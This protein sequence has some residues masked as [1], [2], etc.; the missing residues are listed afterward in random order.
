[1]SQIDEVRRLL[2]ERRDELTTE[3]SR[4]EGAITALG[5]SVA[6]D[7][8]RRAGGSQRKRAAPGKGGAR[9]PRGISRST[10]SKSS[11][12]RAATG[13]TP[14]VGGSKV[15]ASARKSR[16]GRRPKATR[17][18]RL[19]Q[20]VRKKPGIRVAEAAKRMNA[21]A[22]GLYQVRDRLVETGKVR[23]VGKGLHPG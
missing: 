1:M 20:Q 22:S 12:A 19:L 23:V 9:S 14:P 11:P 4:I 15:G 10:S 5:E 16:R 6:E 17:E 13:S 8:P 21:S 2:N 3:L 7:V 18:Q